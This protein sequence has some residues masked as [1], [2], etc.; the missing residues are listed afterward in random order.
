M[1]KLANNKL[2]VADAFGGKL[3]VVDLDAGKVESVREIPAHNISHMA[4]L[5]ASGEKNGAP[6]TPSLPSSRT[7]SNASIGRT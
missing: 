4:W 1:A 5:P 2:I 7:D 6:T 3:A